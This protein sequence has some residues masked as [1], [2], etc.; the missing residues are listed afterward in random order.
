MEMVLTGERISAAE[1]QMYGLVS[2]IHPAD[3]LVNEAIK[4][5]EK[6]GVHSKLTVQLAKEAVNSAYETTLAQGINFERRLF[7]STFASSDRKE[8]MSA[9]VEKR[10]PKFN[11][12]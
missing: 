9:F 3:E 7:H 6:I 11:D 5:A 12:A 4:L 1:A 8:G 2:A 10:K